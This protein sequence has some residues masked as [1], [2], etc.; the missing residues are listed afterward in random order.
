DTEEG[1]ALIWETILGIGEVGRNGN[2]FDLGG[3]SLSVVQ[4]AAEVAE[5]FNVSLSLEEVY[6]TPFLDSC[7]ALIDAAE[8]SYRKPIRP[9]S[10]RRIHPASSLQRRMFILS[11]QNPGSVAYNIPMSFAFSQ[12]IDEEKMHN[13]L[14]RLVKRHSILRTSL[15]LHNGATVQNV[16]KN[17]V[18]DFQSLNCAEARLDATLKSLIRPF[19][20]EQCPLLHSALVK[21]PKRHVLLLDFHHS[22]CDQATMRI[23]LDDLA[24]LYSGSEPPSPS[25]DYKDC[26]VWLDDYLLSETMRKQG[27]Y[28]RE[29]LS[30]ELPLLDLFTEKKRTGAMRG[31]VCKGRIDEKTVS[32]ARAFAKQEGGTFFTAMMAAFSLLL[33]KQSGQ[34]ELIIGTPV[35]GRTHAQMQSVVGAFINTL[36]IVCKPDAQQSVRD[37]FISTGETLTRALDHQDYPFDRI[38]AD[39]RGRREADR[40]PLFDVMLVLGKDDLDLRLTDGSAKASAIDTSTAKLDISLYLYEHEGGL[41]CFLEYDKDLFSATAARHILDRFMHTVQTMFVQPDM[42]LKDICVMPDDEYELVTQRFSATDEP[43]AERPLHEWIED[44]ALSRPDDI[45]V[46]SGGKRIT[47]SELNIRANRIAHSLMGRGACAGTVVALMMQRGID[48][49]PALFG[50]MKTGAAYLPV[51]PAYPEERV[52]FML[53]DSCVKILLHDGD[54]RGFDGTALSLGD[55]LAFDAH[56]NPCIEHSMDDLAYIIYTSGSTGL[57]KGSMLKKRGVAN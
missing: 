31:G 9:A 15:K 37:Y 19:D 12:P 27:D 23:L 36:P 4:M 13:A 22:I 35:S 17:A 29:K 34:E 1:L 7:A 39:C 28:W 50:I 44:L 42:L 26:A 49:M 6:K 46:V 21:T 55:C 25:L 30:G 51:D 2:F 40:N 10:S 11:K 41:E 38:V 20:I 8:S 43:Y 33:S 5:K 18:L 16:Q 3:D 54:P 52:A 47:F 32:T 24:M 53:D 48:L 45:A 56:E 57:P 14:D